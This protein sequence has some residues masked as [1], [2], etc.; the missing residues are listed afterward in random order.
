V[1]AKDIWDMGGEPVD[2]IA[3]RLLWKSPWWAKA[4][5]E[6]QYAQ[7]KVTETDF[8]A[9]LGRLYYDFIDLERRAIMPEEFADLASMA[10]KIRWKNIYV[11]GQ[12]LSPKLMRRR[13][14]LL[15]WN[16][17]TARFEV[18]PCFCRKTN[19]SVDRVAISKMIKQVLQHNERD[20]FAKV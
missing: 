19:R 9:A 10:S 18:A 5:V 2:L 8:V 7:V 12:Q 4:L 14:S 16:S 1:N 13:L 17:A 11:R 3:A 20:D 15:Q 6:K